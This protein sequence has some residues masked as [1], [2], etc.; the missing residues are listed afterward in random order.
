MPQNG[1]DLEKETDTWSEAEEGGARGEC[2]GEE[3]GADSSRAGGARLSQPQQAPFAMVLPSSEAS[4]PAN[5]EGYPILCNGWSCSPLPKPSSPYSMD[6]VH[7]KE[8][9][10]VS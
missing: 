2:K 6:Q 4:Q 9:Q 5:C 1:R 10:D 7:E 3:E 8:A